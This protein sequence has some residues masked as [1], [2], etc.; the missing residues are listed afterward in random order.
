MSSTARLCV[1]IAGGHSCTP[2]VRPFPRRNFDRWYSAWSE[3]LQLS[4]C[5]LLCSSL[6]FMF[7]LSALK[8]YLWLQVTQCS[9][10]EGI[11]WTHS[12]PNKREQRAN[13]LSCERL[14]EKG[15]DMEVGGEQKASERENFREKNK[16]NWGHRI[17]DLV[18]VFK[19]SSPNC[20]TWGVSCQ[21]EDT[22]RVKYVSLFRLP[23]L[24]SLATQTKEQI[25]SWQ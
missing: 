14:K 8:C 1:C 3:V 23:G 11:A 6:L 12:A 15:V 5:A 16:W 22:S 9:T 19:R 17:F 21:A 20:P 7:I 2:F 18:I 10:E 13:R 25:G 4:E 24:R